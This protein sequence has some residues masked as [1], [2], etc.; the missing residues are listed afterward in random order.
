MQ[1]IFSHTK[2]PKGVKLQG[3]PMFIIE[4]LIRYQLI[5][6][7]VRITYFLCHKFMS[8]ITFSKKILFKTFIKKTATIKVALQ[9]LRDKA[10]EI[11][12]ELGVTNNKRRH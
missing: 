10:R 11:C 2:G 8:F 3:F 1:Q 6:V 9:L 4:Y 5:V 12:V 7:Y